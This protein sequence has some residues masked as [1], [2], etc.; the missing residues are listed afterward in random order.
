[1]FINGYLRVYCERCGTKFDLY[2]NLSLDTVSTI[3]NN[4]K[5]I[6]RER[7]WTVRANER[8]YC[9]DCAKAMRLRARNKK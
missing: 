1:M 4:A 5:L 3:K 8:A 7:G 9:P 2:A 6:A